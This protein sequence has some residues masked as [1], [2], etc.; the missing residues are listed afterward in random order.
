MN[1]VGIITDIICYSNLLTAITKQF[2]HVLHNLVLVLLI[3]LL[4]VLALKTFENHPDVCFLNTDS[5][6]F[7]VDTL[8]AYVI[9]VLF[10][11][12]Q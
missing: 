3:I 8:A 9:V 4:V 2:R 12:F 1:E 5:T 11:I 6:R 10:V 7:N